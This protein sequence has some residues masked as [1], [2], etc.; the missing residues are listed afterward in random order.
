MEPTLIHLTTSPEEQWAMLAKGSTH[1]FPH[2]IN[3]LID[4]GL[5][6]YERQGSVTEVKIDITIE[7]YDDNYYT[8]TY[9]DAGPGILLQELPTALS[10]GKAKRAGLNEH[11]A[12]LKNALAFCCPQATDIWE[13][14]SRPA[15]DPTAYRITSPYTSPICCTPVSV[16]Q[17]AYPS[18]LTIR[19]RTPINT[20]RFYKG[21]GS[22][23]PNIDTIGLKLRQCISVTYARHPFLNSDEIM[24]RIRVNNKLVKPQLP[25]SKVDVGAPVREQIRFSDSTP[26]VT[27]ELRHYRLTKP[28][29]NGGEYFQRNT[30]SS[31]V[32]LYLHHRLIRRIPPS[33]LYG[34]NS[35]HN[36]FN[37]FVCIVD[38]YG[39][40]KGVPPTMTT[41]NGL[42]DTHPTKAA[43]MEWIR[44]KVPISD[45]RGT[46]SEGCDRAENAMVEEFYNMR[47]ANKDAFGPEYRILL[48]KSHDIDAATKTTPLDILETFSDHVVMYEAKKGDATLDDISQIHRNII[49]LH[50]VPQYA[51]VKIK[52]VLISRTPEADISPICKLMLEYYRTVLPDTSYTMN[53]KTWNDY[54]ISTVV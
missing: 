12:G 25:E 27:A 14:I 3:E 39:D 53:L 43:L 8:V 42:I 24:T 1:E 15:D 41:K 52:G 4:N 18:G 45:G 36:D 26:E 13:I 20:L 30:S 34:L 32:Y 19:M 28:N 9:V 29:E 50:N 5:A 38:V 35:N 10:V 46:T 54:R 37:P 6:A 31:G 21:S 49:L 44:S 51:G 17:H 48:N 16:S 33:E 11:G 7:Q 22:G 2:A 40:P 23:K 47:M